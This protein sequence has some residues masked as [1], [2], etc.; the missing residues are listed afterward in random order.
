MGAKTSPHRE[1]TGQAAERL[2]VD[3]NLGR[4]RSLA[5]ISAALE[6]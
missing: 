3:A 2:A 6:L 1:S 5:N 4:Q